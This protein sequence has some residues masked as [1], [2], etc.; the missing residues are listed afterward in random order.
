VIAQCDDHF[1]NQE[2]ITKG[3]MTLIDEGRAKQLYRSMGPAIE[4][5]GGSVANT[6]AGI[7]SFGGNAAFIGKVHADQLGEVFTH[8]MRSVGV[9]CDVV[10]A[11]GGP[12]TA[13]SLIL[14]T[15]DAQRSMNTFLGISGLL[16]PHDVDADLVRASTLLFCEGYLWDV[17]SAKKAIRFAMATAIGAGNRVALSLSDTFCVDR[18]HSEFRELVAGPVDTLFANRAELLRLYDTDDIEEAFEHLGNDV[19]LGCV[20]MGTLGSMLIDNGRQIKI[21]AY[22]V[23]SVLDTTG[24][25]DQYAAGVLFGLAQGRPLEECG[26]L[27]SLAAAEVIT[28]VGPRP[29]NPLAELDVTHARVDPRSWVSG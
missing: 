29:L 3:G 19:S 5:S 15:P 23:G 4:A 11:N 14:V 27:G 8:D 1:L 26:R 10:G 24:A 16:E 2:S 12:A 7:A 6:M 21:P 28:H 9:A 22:E 13:R 18:H 20:T 17:E 25:G